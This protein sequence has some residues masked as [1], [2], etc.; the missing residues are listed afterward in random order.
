MSNPPCDIHFRLRRRDIYSLASRTGFCVIG[1]IQPTLR[2]VCRRLQRAISEVCYH[3]DRQF[4]TGLWL[5]GIFGFERG[6]GNILVG[7]IS[8]L[9]PRSGPLQN[10]E[11]IT[12]AYKPL[13]PFVGLA[14]VV[15]SVGGAGSALRSGK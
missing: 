9:S 4:G 12:A 13:I 5:Y 11:A 15:S 8:G 2:F 3:P 14:F 6:L 10:S 1:S 7:P